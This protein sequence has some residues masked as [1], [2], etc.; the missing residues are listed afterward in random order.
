VSATGSCTGKAY[1][2]GPGRRLAVGHEG[3]I[4]TMPDEF[5]DGLLAAIDALVK[6]IEA[7]AEDERLLLTRLAS[8][9]RSRKSGVPVTEALAQEADPGALQV[10][11]RILL[12]LTEAS[13]V[14]RRAL[15]GAMRSE[16]TSI[17]AIAQAFGVS[18]QRVSNIL[19]R[20]PPAGDSMHSLSHDEA[21]EA[22]EQR[23]G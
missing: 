11:G 23:F 10:L 6:A 15:A 5:G 17:P 8:L 3:H 7:N 18:H 1:V 2:T 22:D 20:P 12:R 9:R 16:G 14:A 19:S 4:R 21:D 13:G